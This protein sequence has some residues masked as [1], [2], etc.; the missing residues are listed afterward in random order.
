MKRTRCSFV[1]IEAP[2]S[3]VPQ[4]NDFLRKAGVSASK[5]FDGVDGLA[6]EITDDLR[7]I[8]QR[9]RA[10][11]SMEMTESIGLDPE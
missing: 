7:S 6:E 4:V 11:K 9:S 3:L 1:K 2:C 5:L 10:S 8:I